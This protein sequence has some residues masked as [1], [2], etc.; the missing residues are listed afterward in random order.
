MFTFLF[1]IAPN[2]KQWECPSAGE[3]IQQ[4]VIFLYDEILLWKK[5]K[6]NGHYT[7]SW[8][9]PRTVMLSK[10]RQRQKG[11]YPRI[12]FGWNART[13]QTNVL[14]LVWGGIH[15]CIH[16]SRWMYTLAET[17]WTLHLRSVHVSVNFNSILKNGWSRQRIEC[18]IFKEMI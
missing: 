4:T 13:G 18:V 2:W 8:L 11:I 10:V 12:P 17:Q 6:S 1:I 16:R 14:A 15:E 5:K 7:K 9:D 3:W